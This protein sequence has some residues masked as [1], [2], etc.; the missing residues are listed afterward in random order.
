ME[1]SGTTNIGAKTIPVYL[2]LEHPMDFFEFRDIV[3]AAR[4]DGSDPVKK[5]I[6]LGYD[7]V[8]TDKAHEFGCLD[9]KNTPKTF[10]VF[11]PNQIKSA[12]G[13]KGTYNSCLLYTSRC[14]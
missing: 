13:N 10:I 7:G 12:I 1:Y 11:S 3:R 2:R 4:K 8:I 6:K 9:V 5:T 14:V